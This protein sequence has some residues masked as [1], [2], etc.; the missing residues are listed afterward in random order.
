M[1]ILYEVAIVAAALMA[2]IAGVTALVTLMQLIAGRVPFGFG[3]I[4]AVLCTA[5]AVLAVWGGGS[6]AK[7][8]L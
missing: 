6:L 5:T 2:I 1:R 4:V 8:I 3:I 7:K